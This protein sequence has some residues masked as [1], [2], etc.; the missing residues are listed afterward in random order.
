MPRKPSRS[1]RGTRAAAR[2]VP[3]RF[4]APPNEACWIETDSYDRAAFTTL[5]EQSPSLAEVI[6]VGGRLVPRF[7]AL[8]EDLFALCFKNNIV[9]RDTTAVAP[10]VQPH[11]GL[12]D[13]LAAA[14]ALAALREHTVLDE[15]QAGLGAVL[16]AEEL[17]TQ[18]RNGRLWNRA[19]LRDLWDLRAS[20]DDL[21]H[22]IE[23][24]ETARDLLVP[25]STD[26]THDEQNPTRAEAEHAEKSV[27]SPDA[28]ARVKETTRDLEHEAEV[29]EATLRQKARRISERAGALP[30]D[31]AMRLQS[32][33]L[34]TAREL[35]ERSDDDAAWGLGLGSDHRSSPGQQLELGRRLA[36][37]PKLKRLARLVGRMRESALRL[38]KTVLE[39]ANEEAHT[40]GCGSE[41]SRLLPHELVGIRHPVLRR[42]FLRRLVEREL[43]LYELRGAE[44]K[45]RGPMVVCLDGSASMAGDKELWSKAVSLTLLDI[46]R[47]QRRLF[48]F[49]CFSSADQP[50]WTLDLNPRQRYQIDERK[51]YDLAEYFPGGGTDFETPLNAAMECLRGA[52]YKRGDI[53]FITDGECSVS[54]EWLR[55]FHAEKAQLGCFVF[56]VLIDV[57][58]STFETVREFS[59]RVTSVSS[60]TE[61][62][63]D[64]LFV[65]V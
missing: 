6:D 51:V 8:V 58:T 22:K 60:L 15:V 21:R 50:L 33:A 30:K 19:D 9:F 27:L 61:D 32:Q 62:A 37:N 57:G 17:L 59:D 2:R 24:Y 10:S 26:D 65:A 3:R 34:S 47:R 29:A 52:R 4:V 41:L 12:L 56:S 44:E 54:P 23:T 11:R 49:L 14:A 48:R 35:G 43:Q 64:D 31:G 36:S 45:G 18:I 28:R 53:V 40:V 16:L 55:T 7:T 63:V 46:A 13:S 20:E 1:R 42:D 38:R 25:D 39:R 5:R